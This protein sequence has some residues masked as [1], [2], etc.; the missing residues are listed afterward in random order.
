MDK[1]R[2]SGPPVALQA[3]G[4]FVV[5]IDIETVANKRFLDAICG[6]ISEALQR[7]CR[8]ATFNRFTKAEEAPTPAYV[9]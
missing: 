4:I 1:C 3:I 2:S 7:H 6:I 8:V 9:G 5:W